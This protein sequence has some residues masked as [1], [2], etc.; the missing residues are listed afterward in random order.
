MGT[1]RGVEIRADLE[2][3][4]RL[5]LVL[6]A[7]MEQRLRLLQAPVTE[8]AE[9]LA[10]ALNGNPFLEVEEEGMAAAPEDPAE[11]GVLEGDASPD[12][13]GPCAPTFPPAVARVQWRDRVLSQ[14]RLGAGDAGDRAIAEYILGNLD[15]RGYLAGGVVEVALAL[16]V[17][18][19]AVE[20]VR[21]RLMRLDPVG[22][23]AL[24]LRECLWV[25]LELRGEGDSLAARVVREGLEDLAR[26]YLARLAARLGATP[27]A[28]RQA[29]ARIRDLCPCPRRLIEQESAPPVFPDLRVERIAGRYEVFPEEGPLPRLRLV[30]PPAMRPG[31]GSEGLARFIRTRSARARW[32]I[33]G[34]AARRR[35]LVGVM[36][37]IVEEQQGFFD[38]GVHRLKPLIYRQLADRLGVHESTVAR[39]VRGKYVQTPGGIYPLRFFFSKGLAGA[40]GLVSTPASVRARVRELIASE[41]PAR[42]L[43]DEDLARML[44][45]EGVRISRRTVAKYRDQ[46]RIAKASYR[47]QA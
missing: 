16:G 20:A 31:R 28:V 30:Q 22:L 37:L 15:D 45:V 33:E 39:A 1:H 8:L 7:R 14:L 42:P 13:S 11:D 18:P 23:G 47:R 34:L 19:P 24:D 3:G 32:L 9:I 21:Q 2:V 10:E 43:T 46:M 17:P 36:R 40:A 44:R 29:A 4:Q 6:T 27:E 38:H 35:T 12:P 5:Q 26:C 25:Q 41:A